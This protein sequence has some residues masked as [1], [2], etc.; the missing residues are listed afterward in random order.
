MDWT[1]LEQFL[2][3]QGIKGLQ[4][5][6]DHFV[7]FLQWLINLLPTWPQ[8]SIPVPTFDSGFVNALN[9]IFPVGQFITVLGIVGTAI[10]TYYLTLFVRHVL[11]S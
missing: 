4:G 8:M 7:T 9:W 11:F 5:F 3:D 1:T 2:H 6:L 10:T